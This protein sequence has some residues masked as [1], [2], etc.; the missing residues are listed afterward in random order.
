MAAPTV[1]FSDELEAWLDG[2][3]EKTLGGLQMVFE[4]RTFAVAIFILMAP[5]SLPLPTGGLTYAL[6]ITTILLALE[7]VA[8]RRTVWLPEKWKAR[9]LGEVTTGRAIPAIVRIIRWCERWSRPR[10]ARLIDNALAWRVL[11]VLLGALTTAAML[12]PPFSG[13]DT[14]PALGVVL[15]ALSI[16]LQDLVV[17][18]VG[19]VVG[20]AGTAL[21]LTV[22]AAVVRVFRDFF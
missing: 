20:I 8:G 11:G 19:L 4:E 2:E 1:P 12:A 16:L 13:L 5:T 18:V 15:I 14:L 17:A 22:G 6:E 21:M 9:E 10:G 3:R 7:M